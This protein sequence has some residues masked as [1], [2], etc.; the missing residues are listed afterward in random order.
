MN[1]NKDI[2]QLMLSL[3]RIRD[4]NKLIK[5]FCE[6]LSEIFEPRKFDY[7]VQKPENKYFMEIISS[8]NENYGYIVSDEPETDE[9][10]EQVENG[11]QML[12]AM[13]ERIDYE[14]RLK[15]EADSHKKKADRKESEILKHIADLEKA[16]D[17]SLNLIYDLQ[18]EITE[19]K[20]AEN[21]LRIRQQQLRLIYDSV[22]DIIYYLKVEKGPN[23]RFISVNKAF[24]TATALKE[25]QVIGKTIDQVIPEPSLQM[26]RSNYS[27]AI[28]E[29]NIVY[30]EETSQYPAGMKTG[31]VS[32]API[33]DENG[34]CAHLIGSVHD[35]TDR[36]C[37]ME[38]L[39]RKNNELQI[40][41]DA[42]VGRELN[43][44]ELKKEINKLL[45]KYGEK[46]KYEII[47]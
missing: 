12:A 20:R 29:K 2:L 32:I 18:I 15:K 7:F 25:D 27:K 45:E 6:K 34:K 30:W 1:A 22:G 28:R 13:L 19:R 46:P 8:G 41:Y 35:I 36:K 17:A 39:K 16:S 40:F 44:I 31:I 42:A 23:Y 33:F 47:E 5:Y 37:A 24:L 3:F 10:R 38:E 9:N 21:E 43:I 4:R 11:V 26:V 14:L